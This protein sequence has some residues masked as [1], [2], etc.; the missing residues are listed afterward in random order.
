MPD[1]RV[2][3]IVVDSRSTFRFEVY[4]GEEL[5]VMTYHGGF[6]DSKHGTFFLATPYHGKETQVLYR[7]VAVP[8]EVSV[9]R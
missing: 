7:M 5:H 3:I 2:E 4:I 8:A 6:I 1:P 9:L